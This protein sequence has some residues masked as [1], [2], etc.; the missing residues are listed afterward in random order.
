MN[1]LRSKKD[2]KTSDA[3][4]TLVQ[5]KQLHDIKDHSDLVITVSKQP[6]EI[7]NYTDVLPRSE[8]AAIRHSRR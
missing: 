3:L 4:A 5:G 1:L 8:K 2:P 6:Q 7:S